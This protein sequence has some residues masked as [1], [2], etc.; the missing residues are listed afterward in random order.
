MLKFLVILVTI[1]TN[2]ISSKSTTMGTIS[3]NNILYSLPTISDDK[4]IFEMPSMS[5]FKDAPQF[6]EDEWCQL[7]FFN[8]EKLDDIKKILK[9]YKNFEAKHR[10]KN[11]WSDIYL[12]KLNR[13]KLIDN[14]LTLDRLSAIFETKLLSAPILTTT[15][16]PLGAVKNGFSIKV[17]NGVLLY[18]T[19]ENN[20]IK[21]LAATIEPNTQ[22]INLTK[23]FIK[24][25]KEFNLILVDWL[26][27]FI[28]VSVDSSGK[29]NIWNP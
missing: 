11:G 5:T 26:Q 19:K 8:K 15:S 20:K 7:E 17:A 4:I 3:T 1:S 10:K 16:R 12:R 23:S 29:I 14:S 18:G 21:I 9:E 24:L 6:H 22:S 13:D 25:N 27:Q 28:L 2:T